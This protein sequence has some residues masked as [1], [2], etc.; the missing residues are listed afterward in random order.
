MV[1][2][3][4]LAEVENNAATRKLKVKKHLTIPLISMAHTPLLV[5]RMLGEPYT[6][7]HII[8]LGKDQDKPPLVILVYN[9][10][11]DREEI[12]VI[13]SL[14]ASAFQRAEPPLKGR[15]FRFESRGIRDGKNYRDIDVSEME[16]E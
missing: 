13:N 1:T 11:N 4:K 10:D 16:E 9:F 12:L 14:I 2:L 6:D 7:T 3:R 15:I 5:A 8:T